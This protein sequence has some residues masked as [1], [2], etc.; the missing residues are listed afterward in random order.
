MPKTSIAHLSGAERILILGPCGAGKSTIARRLGER[1]NINVLHLD[2]HYWQPGWVE[3]DKEDWAKTVNNLIKGDKWIIDG[4]YTN[5][6]QPRLDRANAIIYLKYHTWKCL[7]RIL[8]RIWVNRGITRPDMAEGC[9]E[10]FDLEFLHYVAVFNITRGRK[11]ERM[12]S[13]LAEEKSVI[14]LKSD[15]EVLTFL[16]SMESSGQFS[17]S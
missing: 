6:I 7:C 10:R 16:E 2:Q 11:I 13:K 8:K 1:L 9:I 15:S 14:I 17:S 4:N 12:I 5:T 3:P